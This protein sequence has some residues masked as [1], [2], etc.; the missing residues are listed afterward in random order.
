M[1]QKSPCEECKSVC[2]NYKRCEKYKKWVRK[3]W[4][5]VQ[6]LYAE[7]KWATDRER[8]TE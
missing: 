4:R 7:Q 5:E 2:T 1:T 6:A 8:D 3:A